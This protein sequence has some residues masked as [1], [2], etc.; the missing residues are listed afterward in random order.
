LLK[1]PLQPK[2]NAFLKI[3]PLLLITL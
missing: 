1:T 3:S 2:K